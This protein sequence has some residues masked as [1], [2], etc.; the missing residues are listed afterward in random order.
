MSKRLLF[1]FSWVGWL[2]IIVL[3]WFFVR[4]WYDDDGHY[5]WYRGIIP[6]TGWNSN[7]RHW[8]KK[9]RDRAEAQRGT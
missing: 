8:S 5:G 7:Y 9:T 1:G 4:L 2:N 3:Q 6:T